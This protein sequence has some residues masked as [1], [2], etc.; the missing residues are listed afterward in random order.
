MPTLDEV[1]A[2]VKSVGGPTG[3]LAPETLKDLPT[4]LWPD[5]RILGAIVGRHRGPRAL[6]V[7]TQWR[8]LFVDRIGLTSVSYTH[9]TLPTIYSV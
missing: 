5:E 1:K 6:A 3:W 4:V 8:V 2:Q 9:L 7:A